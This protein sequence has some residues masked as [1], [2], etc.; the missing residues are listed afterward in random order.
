[1]QLFEFGHRQRTGF[2][3]Q[4][5]LLPLRF[6]MNSNTYSNEEQKALSK[7]VIVTILCM[8]VG[9]PAREKQGLLSL[10]GMTDPSGFAFLAP[11]NVSLFLVIPLRVQCVGVDMRA[12]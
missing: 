7:R 8:F 10:D 3:A 6:L 11:S 1:M 4:A 12:P 9:G 5:A 2:P